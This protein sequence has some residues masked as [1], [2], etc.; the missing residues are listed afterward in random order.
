MPPTQT[1]KTQAEYLQIFTSLASQCL[2]DQW[3]VRGGFQRGKDL[4]PFDQ[5]L[6]HEKK[7]LDLD[8]DQVRGLVNKDSLI[9]FFVDNIKSY[10]KRTWNKYCASTVYG[11]SLQ[12]K[13]DAEEFKLMAQNLSMQCKRSGA[14]K[15]TASLKRRSL[16]PEE[17]QRLFQIASSSP[18]LNEV[19]VATF[20]IASVFTGLRPSEFANAIFEDGSI[21]VL[22]SKNTNGRST[23]DIRNVPVS[24]RQW[25]IFLDSLGVQVSSDFRASLESEESLR[26]AYVEQALNHAA[27]ITGGSV[28]FPV[29]DQSESRKDKLSA[30][31]KSC[32][33]SRFKDWEKSPCPYTGRHVFTA[34]WKNILSKEGVATLLGHASTETAG[35][36]YA[37][38]VQGSPMFRGEYASGATQQRNIDVDKD[39]S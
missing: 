28:D 6:P 19:R 11:L 32:S 22:N 25:I 39:R 21:F 1:Q 26:I 10:S 20:I 34:N 12:N 31:F 38:R 18:R 15:R 9:E 2:K 24:T 13:G 7:F 33:A 35:K 37:R 29:N 23:G 14:D 4:S 36:H 17:M 30:F 16:K 27:V 5:P 3:Q 8:D